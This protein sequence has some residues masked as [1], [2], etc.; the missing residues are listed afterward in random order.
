MHLLL[1]KLQ[2]QSN[3]ENYYC[4]AIAKLLQMY[5]TRYVTSDEVREGCGYKMVIKKDILNYWSLQLH[6]KCGQ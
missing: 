1:A 6:L 2:H 5:V 4:C 3:E